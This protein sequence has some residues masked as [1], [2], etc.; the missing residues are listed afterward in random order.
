MYA[1][2]KVFIVHDA[3]GICQSLKCN[4]AIRAAAASNLTCYL[5][6]VGKGSLHKTTQPVSRD[7]NIIEDDHAKLVRLF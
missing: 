1:A 5:S 7:L 2:L 3:S 6:T 4:V